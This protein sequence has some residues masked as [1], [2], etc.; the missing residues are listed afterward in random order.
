[1]KS[2]QH[3]W[4]I[5]L[6]AG[7]NRRTSGLK[8]RHRGR[9]LGHFFKHFKLSEIFSEHEEGKN[10]HRDDGEPRYGVPHFAVRVFRH[11][12]FAVDDEDHEDEHEGKD[13]SVHDLR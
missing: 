3:T 10:D 1:M 7:K 9:R 11:H 6:R 12:V 8:K 13:D 4:Q 5:S 2:E